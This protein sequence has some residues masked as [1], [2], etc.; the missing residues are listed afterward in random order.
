MVAQAKLQLVA[1][2][3]ILLTVFHGV[4]AAPI[5]ENGRMKRS[6]TCPTCG[7]GGGGAGGGA[8]G[9]GDAAGAGGEDV[10]ET[11]PVWCKPTNVFRSRV[12]VMKSSK[13]WRGYLEKDNEEEK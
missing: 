13:S 7:A 3:F 11:T 10:E 6:P 9:A 4:A 12:R 1:G 5:E 8:G 2:L